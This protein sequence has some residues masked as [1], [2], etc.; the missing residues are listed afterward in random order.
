MTL[1]KAVC[2]FCGSNFGTDPAYA[3]AAG[4]LGQILAKKKVNL[5][6]GGGNVGLMGKIANT[7]HKLG[8]HVTS[9]VPK[10]IAQME[11][12]FEDA[13]ETIVTDNMHDRK[14]RMFARS[15][16]FIVLPGGIGT[17]EEIVEVLSWAYLAFHSKPIVLVNINNYW[18]PFLHLMQH[19]VDHEF[20]RPHLVGSVTGNDVLLVAD[21]A[22]QVLP[23]I[24]ASLSYRY[25]DKL[26]TPAY[27]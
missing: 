18:D 9:I 27:S 19:L 23:L 5:V 2:V 6:F 24:E 7:V 22:E 3:Q 21:S 1:P 25:A 10:A 17:L 20:A 26:M 14:G 8:G 13:D 4:D 11:D 12:Q 16:A 15:D